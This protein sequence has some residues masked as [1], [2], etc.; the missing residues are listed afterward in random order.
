M[1]TEQYIELDTAEAD[2]V[3]AET[4]DAV[5]RRCET[6]ELQLENAELREQVSLR[7]IAIMERD[8]LLNELR[9]Q[10]GSAAVANLRQQYN[11]ALKRAQDAEG[12]IALADSRQRSAES[13]AAGFRAHNQRFG[14]EVA[15]LKARIR[16]LEA[17]VATSEAEFAALRKA[18]QGGG[19]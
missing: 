12:K 10:G 15:Q 11:I 19:E 14:V 2:T 16:E 9:E 6:L 13:A 1:T 18:Q 17:E 3:P 4:Y 8:G 7:D 5:V